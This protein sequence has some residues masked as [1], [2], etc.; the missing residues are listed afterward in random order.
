MKHRFGMFAAATLVS[1]A[2]SVPAFALP[3]IG[4]ASVNDVI[5]ANEPADDIQFL[6]GVNTAA[7]KNGN[8]SAFAEQ[9][10]SSGSG[11]W[12][13]LGKANN[14]GLSQDVAT[15]KNG[16]LIIEFLKETNKTGKWSVTNTN[17][18]MDATVDLVFAMHASN[19][20]TAF[21]FDDQSIQA[22]KTV[23]GT[24]QI[25]W[26]NNGGR[27]PAFSNIAFFNRDLRVAPRGEDSNNPPTEVPEPATLALLGLGMLGMTCLRKQRKA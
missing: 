25:K 6:A 13:L 2:V 18:E 15:F 4:G 22:G 10:A 26:L 7:G 9:W 1:L 14:Q 27:I 3:T 20:S 17:I 19:A 5:L 8:I 24:W 12:S 21:L 11:N 23:E 16:D